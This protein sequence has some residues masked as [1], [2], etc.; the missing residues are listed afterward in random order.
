MVTIRAQD[1]ASRTL[2]RVS[3][4]IAGMSRAEQLLRRQ[5]QLNL[6]QARKMEQI[7]IAEQRLKDLKV[8]QRYGKAVDHHKRQLAELNRLQQRYTQRGM[9]DNRTASLEQIVRHGRDPISG[10]FASARVAQQA[11]DGMAREAHT[12]LNTMNTDIANTER[13]MGKLADHI[14]NKMPTS[15]QRMKMSMDAN[16]KGG[17]IDVDREIARTAATLRRLHP[18]LGFIR[19]DAEIVARAIKQIPLDNLD[20]MGH[21]LSGVGRTMQLFGAIG[22][23]SLGMAS[24]KAAEFNT[25]MSLAATQARNIG[26]PATQVTRRI[27]QLTNGFTHN[28]VELQ[29]VLDLMNEFP[30]DS[31]QMSAATYDIFSSMNL[32]RNGVMDVAKGLELL[33]DANKI[34]VAGGVELKEGTNAMIT[35]LN[36]FDPQLENTTENFD[37]MFDIVRFGR[38]RLSE[39]NIMMNKIAPATADAGNNLEDVAG[40]MAY[41]TTV[42]PSQRMVATGISRL[43]EALR[44][45]DVV[46]GLDEMGVKIKDAT[47]AMRPFDEVLKDIAERFPELRTGAMSA[48][49]FFREVTKTGRGGGRG[50]TFTAEGRRALSQIMK[51]FD[52]YLERQRQIETNQG[53]FAASHAAQMRALG[54]QWNIFMNRV[55]AVVIAIGTDA[56]PVF[57]ELGEL[58]QKFLNWWNSLNP[59]MRQGIVRLAALAAIG[60]LVAGVFLAIVGSMFAFIAMTRKMMLSVDMAAM[61][62]KA[63]QNMLRGFAALYA[64]SILVKFSMGGDPKARD[65]VMAMLTGAAAG[66]TFGPWG[67]AA[68]AIIMPVVLAFIT[69]NNNG[70]RNSIVEQIRKSTENS[71]PEMRR[72]GKYLARQIE[73]GFS[74]YMSQSEFTA[75]QRRFKAI[76][77]IETR[78]AKVQHETA[79]ASAKAAKQAAD[80]ADPWKIYHKRMKLYNDQMKKYKSDLRDYTE[81]VKRWDEALADAGRTAATTVAD[82]LQS[83][84]MQMR[85]ANEQAF[86]ELFQ[87]PWLTSETFDLAKQWGIT[88]TIDDMIMDLN[89]QNNR[90]VKWRNTIDAV[91][92]RGVPQDFINEIRKMG[93]E[94]GQHFLDQLAT[95]KPE[96][97][98]KLIAQWKRRNAQIQSQTKMDFTDEIERF[99]KAG[100][101]MGNAI[102]EGFQNAKVGAWFDNWV[103]VMFPEVIDA[104]VKDAIAQWKA[105]NPAP[106][107]P[108]EPQRPTV[109]TNPANSTKAD[110]SRTYNIYITPPGLSGDNPASR[111]D[112]ERQAAFIVS[113][114]LRRIG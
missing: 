25:E 107:A 64:I 22:T 100:L 11:L 39:F 104:A 12:A 66:S 69:R 111:K 44:H 35:V 45:E 18:E 43:I 68:G 88:P 55:R 59:E 47:G 14:A 83:M 67:A 50:L 89:Q 56:I 63:F 58:L 61:K 96:Q 31:Q 65:F 110:N 42:M 51:H 99:K 70:L 85:T 21:A 60:T 10:R 84:F 28:G 91:M 1:F 90:F 98:Q 52:E 57:S 4:E 81:E 77:D 40:A 27:D 76:T 108:K 48:Q 114:I 92:K 86:G 112:F 9:W 24:S 113:G 93:P 15:F 75:F 62:M 2:R 33:R 53:E 80:A 87:G 6:A 46:A 32:E 54:V 105:A 20:R 109:P 17:L 8:L 73:L 5:Q 72:Y 38:M 74:D 95:A 3:G 41:L 78:R 106:K 82:N 37:T 13:K 7:G 30:A 26:A 36:N 49:E 16:V 23:V 19:E 71:T 29:G 97:L 34:A 79:E 103:K 94:E 101:S 102:V